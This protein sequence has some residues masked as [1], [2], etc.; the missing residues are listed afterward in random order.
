MLFGLLYMNEVFE[1]L[2]EDKRSLLDDGLYVQTVHQ[3]VQ[4]LGGSDSRLAIQCVKRLAELNSKRFLPYWGL[5]L[6]IDGLLVVQSDYLKDVLEM[7]LAMCNGIKSIILGTCKSP[8]AFQ[9]TSSSTK[10]F[11]VLVESF[12]AK[13]LSE[14]GVDLETQ[15][16]SLK[17]CGIIY[18]QLGLFLG[19]DETETRVKLILPLLNDKSLF[20]CAEKTLVSLLDSHKVNDLGLFSDHLMIDSTI[21]RKIYSQYYQMFSK[22]PRFAQM[23]CA[24][25]AATCCDVNKFV[26][27]CSNLQDEQLVELFAQVEY[28]FV[29]L[30]SKDQLEL[31]LNRLVLDEP[32]SDQNL[33]ALSRFACLCEDDRIAYYL[34]Q[35]HLGSLAK[36]KFIDRLVELGK[37]V[38]LMH[39]ESMIDAP[40]TTTTTDILVLCMQSLRKLYEKSRNEQIPKLLIALLDHPEAKVVWNSARCLCMIRFELVDGDY[41][42]QRITAQSNYK[43]KAALIDLLAQSSSNC[44]KAAYVLRDEKSKLDLPNGPVPVDRVRRAIMKFKS[45]LNDPC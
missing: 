5:V 27:F 13:V 33:N 44:D 42:L 45:K 39:I 15:Y 2:I 35:H 32:I 26:D 6:S 31:L 18:A 25:S 16:L 28:S 19:A 17:L 3:I 37:M 30:V 7:L 12:S 4:R 20:H 11:A 43:A 29:D 36:I 34:N 14:A 10:H 21:S 8:Y 41:L 40:S 1:R 22:V 23:D 38:D 24:L 9:S